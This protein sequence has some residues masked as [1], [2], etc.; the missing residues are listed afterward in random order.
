MSSY[1]K[2]RITQLR[3]ICDDR[4]LVHH[5]LTKKQVIDMLIDYDRTMID[6]EEQDSGSD[7]EGE[8]ENGGQVDELDG[9]VTINDNNNEYVNQVPAVGSIEG[10]PEEIVT[11]R[12]RLA[13]ARE[14]R[15]AQD[16]AWEIE[17][18]RSE[19][20]ATGQLLNSQAATNIDVKDVRSLLP[21]MIDVDV[22][23]F[24]MSYERVLELNEIDKAS[25]A[26]YLPAQ[27]SPRALKIFARLSLEESRDY[28][29]V[30]RAILAGFK[31]DAQTYLR[32]FRSMRRTG[33]TT[34]KMLLTNM[35]EVFNRFCDAKNI[36]SFEKLTDAILMEQYLIALPDNVRQFVCTKQPCNVDQCAEF[37][38]L[39][40][41]I[42]KM[43]RENGTGL[44]PRF[45]GG[46]APGPT[47]L[48]PGRPNFSQQNHSG[49]RP[50]AR[51][52]W[53]ANNNSAHARPTAG[54]WHYRERVPGNFRNPG[55]GQSG[56][57]RRPMLFNARNRAINTRR[58]FECWNNCNANVDECSNVA[59]VIDDG[60]CR[61]NDCETYYTDDQDEGTLIYTDYCVPIVINDTNCIAIRDTG[62]F[63][64]LII[65]E[66]LIPKEQISWDRAI[67]C[68]GPFDGNLRRPLPTTR[69]KFR[70]PSL[71]CF[72]DIEVEVGV[73]RLPSG[74]NCIVG[75]QIFKDHPNLT[76]IITVRRCRVGEIPESV[77]RPS[78]PQIVSNGPVMDAEQTPTDTVN[79]TN[80]S[81]L[82]H[83]SD[84][85]TNRI[86]AAEMHTDQTRHV[87]RHATEAEMTDAGK[88]LISAAQNSRHMDG[89]RRPTTVDLTHGRTAAITDTA[90][91]RS[92]TAA[93]HTHRTDSSADTLAVTTR[94]THTATPSDK[95]QLHATGETTEADAVKQFGK[96]DTSDINNDLSDNQD[97]DSD[98]FKQAQVTDTALHSYWTRAKA[99]SNEF[100]IID[101]RLYRRTPVN[102][103]S[104]NEFQLVVPRKYQ[105]Q[106]L[107]IAHDNQTSGHMGAKQTTYRL[108]NHFWWPQLCKMVKKYVKC[109]HDCQMVRPT[110]KQE[111]VPLQPIPVQDVAFSTLTIDVMGGELPR[112]QSGN[113]YLLVIVCNVT[114]FC[115]AIALRNLR[116]KTIASKL[117]EFFCFVGIPKKIIC[118]NMSSFRSELINEIAQKFG[119][120]MNFSAI[121][122]SQS[123][124]QVE[125]IHHVIETMLRKYVNENPRTWD[126][127]IH[128]LLFA[129]REAKQTS[130]NF[131]PFQLVFG[132]RM[133]GLLCVM[134]EMWEHKVPEK[135]QV[136]LDTE[137]YMQ[138]LT[139]TLNTALQAAYS[140]VSDAQNRMKRQYDKH[141]TQREL[142]PGDLALV[143]LP[144]TGQKLRCQYKG[145]YRVLER[146][147][148]N[149][150]KIQ[151]DRRTV[152]MHINQL[153]QYYD[154]NTRDSDDKQ[155]V[156]SDT[157][158]LLAAP[159]IG[160]DF[161]DELQI[162]ADETEPRGAINAD[163]TDGDGKFVLGD[164]LTDEQRRQMTELLM[165][166][167]D[168][169]T[170]TPGRTELI[171]HHIKLTDT[172]PV[173]Q[174]SYR[175]P[176]SLRAEVETELQTMLDQGIIRYD[177]ETRYNSPLLVLKRKTGGLRLV[178]N[179]IELNRKTQ[180][181][182]YQ[183]TNANELISRVAGSKFITIIDLNRFFFQLMIAPECQHL[184]GFYT[185]YGTFCYVR[186]PLGLHGAP[187][188]A[189]RLIDR[190]LR[191]AHK[192][193]NA[194][195]DDISIHSTTWQ[196]H[197]RHVQD[198][199][200]RLRKAGLTANVKKCVFAS[201]RLTLLGHQIIDGQ[202]LPD[203]GKIQVVKNWKPPKNK[204][205][206]KSFLGLSNFFHQYIDH[207]AEICAPLTDLLARNK[208]DKLAWGQRQQEA[209]DNLKQALI[210]RP[211][212]RPPDMSK[213]MKLY[214]DA[215][216]QSISGVL[217]QFDDVNQ[218]DYVIAYASRKL[219]SRE[220]RYS[221]IELELMAIVFALTHFHHWT[222][223]KKTHVYSDHRPLMWLNSITKHS[224]RLARWA[225]ILQNYD[226][227]VTYIKGE[228]QIADA[229]TRLPEE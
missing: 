70:S 14:E 4:G 148:N 96:I 131:S 33:Q 30:K 226:V 116:A 168:V 81:P 160:N 223:G 214:T 108:L 66:E 11:L 12:L 218:C 38:D 229:L 195:L 128:F 155:A 7:S 40:Y 157:T 92:L 196:G 136:T 111:R 46:N 219:L 112:S 224:D 154:D 103:N 64:P 67:F 62:N 180:T 177:N 19:L 97:M 44:G 98:D 88:D 152:V 115:H 68:T 166:Y 82:Q 41:Q 146:L 107:R 191:G 73:A 120:Q 220:T 1:K 79:M 186:L 170:S 189:Q 106:L 5:G 29:A 102:V 132:H 139:E 197:L 134:R 192:Y 208:P 18:Q 43:G 204:T 78:K 71:N 149:N 178:N 23:S 54:N 221:T 125:R 24:F 57:P 22:L 75:N 135:N 28:D 203:E 212:L 45:P 217:M 47:G 187:S 86:T 209:F 188:T 9:E 129:L 90:C 53:S 140:N 199:L 37:A 143:L 52:P 228:K 105:T 200:E 207:H 142:K 10:E 165:N 159:P 194:L 50:P 87:Q 109:C 174:P 206:L 182:R 175:I 163:S 72:D 161:D 84:Q 63:G 39:S 153:R 122:H 137:Q 222:Y 94:S 193:A 164:Q 27:L 35:R 227:E 210:S 173:W 201:N 76:D 42:A 179:F 133:R 138:K 36:D 85:S 3:E 184:T 202:I 215:S 123:H 8:S 145:P 213:D 176:E 77:R 15:L 156:D 114:K 99:G 100:K 34:Y 80:N 162:D 130:T 181:D 6:N 31:L 51:A 167:D 58:D 16:R 83:A 183:M 144:T 151:V 95:L 65:N 211:I 126:Q 141:S 89:G 104:P 190:V 198:I 124:G 169:F 91:E 74:I 121:Y 127:T 13:L 113:K 48:S 25:W 216:K 171:M 185:P 101:G 205:Q 2:N 49:G 172:Q 61:S 93:A 150:Y 21:K 225:L 117:V 26:K 17:K 158:V 59:D 118:D 110:S 32:T 60:I 119:I 55:T 147:P 56:G 69:I 20:L